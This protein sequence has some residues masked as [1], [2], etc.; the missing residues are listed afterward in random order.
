MTVGDEQGE[1]GRIEI[2]AGEQ[3]EVT[4]R[5]TVDCSGASGQPAGSRLGH[6]FVIEA[7]STTFPV[8]MD[9]VTDTDVS[10]DA[11]WC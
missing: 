5:Y 2:P 11:S 3:S 6:L 1:T 8:T 4:I 9:I 10:F 7:H